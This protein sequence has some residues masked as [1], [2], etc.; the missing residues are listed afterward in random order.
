[1]S[2]DNDLS[3][4]PKR[5]DEMMMTMERPADMTLSLRAVRPNIVQSSA[6]SA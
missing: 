3:G 5:P 6:R 4:A 1:M 2:D